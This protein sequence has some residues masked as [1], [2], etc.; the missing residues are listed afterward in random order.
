MLILVA[1][2]VQHDHLAYMKMWKLAQLGQN[3]WAIENPYGPLNYVLGLLID[4][5]VIAPKIFMALFFSITIF[6]YITYFKLYNQDFQRVTLFVFLIP[7]NFL[8]ICITLIYG[9]N[10]TFVASLIGLAVISRQKNKYVMTGFLLSMAAL[11]KIYA[12]LPLLFFVCENRKVNYRILAS[13]VSVFATGYILATIFFGLDFLK[14]NFYSATRMPSLLSP[15]EGLW[16][17]VRPEDSCGEISC[18]N[19]P[20]ILVAGLIVVNPLLVCLGLSFAVWFS[21][22]FELNFLEASNFGLI[23]TFTIYKVVHPQFFISWALILIPL[24]FSTRKVSQ[25]MFYS[26]LPI[27][28][29]LEFFQIIFYFDSLFPSLFTF[30]YSYGGFVFFP[31]SIYCISKIVRF[32]L[33]LKKFEGK[34]IS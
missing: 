17:L 14:N 30:L 11:L 26:L 29:F 9:L 22:K 8:V 33:N 27:L 32:N 18:L 28:F 3:P 1:S 4:F 10:D 24:M 6:Y 16:Q 34:K 21:R 20:Q 23:L 2:G 7:L 12:I 13:F 19:L 15:F 5:N 25:Q 31:L